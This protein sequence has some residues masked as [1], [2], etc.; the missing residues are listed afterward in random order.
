[1]S[2]LVLL[3]T[4]SVI[5]SSLHEQTANVVKSPNA[6]DK[7]FFIAPP[8]LKVNKPNNGSKLMKSFLLLYKRQRK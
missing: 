3:T 6:I 2:D 7:N 8:F 5:S 1:M 4:G